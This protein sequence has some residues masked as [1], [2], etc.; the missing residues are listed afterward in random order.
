MGKPSPRIPPK[1]NKLISQ[2]DQAQ[3]AS[4]NVA[5]LLGEFYT[6]LV[7]EGIPA[8]FAESLTFTYFTHLTGIE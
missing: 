6:V 1:V 7:Q 5:K 2:L 4:V 8:D 3:A